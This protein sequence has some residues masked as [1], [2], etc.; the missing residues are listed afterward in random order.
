MI[1][2]ERICDERRVFDILSSPGV[3]C[4]LEGDTLCSDI[5]PLIWGFRFPEENFEKKDVIL[6]GIKKE[7]FSYEVTF[8]APD[9]EKEETHQVNALRAFVVFRDLR[10]D[11]PFSEAEKSNALALGS[12]LALVC[13][14][15]GEDLLTEDEKELLRSA[16]FLGALVYGVKGLSANSAKLCAE[17]TC[18]KDDLLSKAFSRYA[19]SSSEGKRRKAAKKPAKLLENAEGL[20]DGD[21]AAALTA[22]VSASYMPCEVI[23]REGLCELER[24]ADKILFA[25]GYTGSFPEYELEG[26]YIKFVPYYSMQENGGAVNYYDIGVS[27]GDKSK[28]LEFISPKTG[29]DILAVGCLGLLDR[30]EKETLLKGIACILCGEKPDES[31]KKLSGVAYYTTVTYP[32]VGAFLLMTAFLLSGFGIITFFGLFGFED[33]KYS[34]TSAAA[35]LLGALV[36]FVLIRFSVTGVRAKYLSK[37][38]KK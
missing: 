13:S 23:D 7:E 12:Q 18:G 34:L 32:G 24:D 20:Y 8:C 30:E 33:M 5:G 3:I 6:C 38:K 19:E 36:I 27:F 9:E 2:Y 25:C 4:T 22:S 11:E 21:S 37:K 14:L 28:G 15:Y 17:Y 31:F 26:K 1:N 35:V 16:E 10:I 29:S